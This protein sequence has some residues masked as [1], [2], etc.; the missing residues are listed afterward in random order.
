MKELLLG[1]CGTDTSWRL[2]LWLQE[3]LR[4]ERE[5]QD[6]TEAA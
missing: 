6:P 3:D 5:G 2:I 4:P 1:Y